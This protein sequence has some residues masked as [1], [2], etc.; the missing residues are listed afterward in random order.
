MASYKVYDIPYWQFEG[1]NH[2]PEMGHF[3]HRIVPSVPGIVSFDT[4]NE[5][6]YEK[7]APKSG[8]TNLRRRFI[9][10]CFQN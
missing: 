6:K 2:F 7:I 5:E 10:N 1:G 8:N 4:R 9:D 3:V